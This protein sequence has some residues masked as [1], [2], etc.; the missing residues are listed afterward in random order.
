MACGCGCGGSKFSRIAKMGARQA[1]RRE[2]L[3]APIHKTIGVG[4]FVPLLSLILSFVWI[5]SFFPAMAHFGNY[6]VVLPIWF[7]GFYAINTF[8]AFFA[9]RYAETHY[10]ADYLEEICHILAVVGLSVVVGMYMILIVLAFPLPQAIAAIAFG[11]LALLV[12]ILAVG[13]L[14]KAIKRGL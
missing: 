1:E 5:F 2:A 3:F 12:L 11:L 7:L 9:G 10:L 14:G 13:K 4:T 8:N 6:R